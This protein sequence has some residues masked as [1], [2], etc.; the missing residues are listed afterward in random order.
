MPKVMKNFRIEESIIAD[1]IKI[2]DEEFGGNLTAAIEDMLKHSIAV[3]SVPWNDRDKLRV[4]ARRNDVYD[5][6]EKH[7]NKMHDFFLI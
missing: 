1:A 6:Y 4:Q 7:E 3:R 5:V 2:A